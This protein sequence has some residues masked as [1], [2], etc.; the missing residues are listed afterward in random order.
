MDMADADLWKTIAFEKTK[1]LRFLKPYAQHP[2][3]RFILIKHRYE[4]T[5]Y[6]LPGRIAYCM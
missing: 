4:T 2:A 5:N 1:S 3:D 6:L